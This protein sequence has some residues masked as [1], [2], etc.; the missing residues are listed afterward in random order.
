MG[1][2]W[3]QF[4]KNIKM[5]LIEDTSNRTKLSKL[6]RFKT[7]TSDGEWRSL[8]EYVN[9]M[10]EGQ[11]YIYYISGASQ[12]AVENSPM[13]EKVKAKG[14]EVLYLT[15][16]MDEYAVQNLTEFDGKR[17]MSVTKEGLKFGGDDDDLDKKRTELYREKFSGLTDYLSETYS[18]NVEK[19]IISNRLES[20]PCVLVTSQFGY[21]ANM[22]RIMKAQAFADN[23]RNAFLFSRKTME[24]NPRHPIV[25]ELN[26]RVANGESPEATKDLAMLMYDTALLN[27]GFQ[28]E[29][30]TEFAGRM[31]RV[32]STGMNIDSLELAPE[33]EVPA[34]EEDLDDYEEDELF[35]DNDDEL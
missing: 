29:D 25:V 11:E 4:G 2:F 33:I 22:E 14:F 32:M 23:Q 35:E 7:S 13:L 18:T 10:K 31:Y 17:L 9:D 5:G 30:P 6:L 1:K 12:E 28:M 26:N 19:V 21:S 20:T 3:E 15:D 27:S 16:P 8:E 24:I 34:D